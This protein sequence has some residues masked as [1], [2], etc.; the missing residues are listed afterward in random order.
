MKITVFLAAF[1]L[2]APGA[3]A[4]A[5]A[6]LVVNGDF[7]DGNTGFTSQYTYAAPTSGALMPETRYTIT[8]DP[9]SVHPYW[10]RVGGDN[11]IMVVNGATSAGK[12]VWQENIATIAGQAYQFTASAADVCCN[13]AHPGRYAASELEFEVSADNFAHFTTLATIDTAPPKDAGQF[14]TATAT[15][16]ATG[17]MELR[18]VDAL[19]GRVGND[20]ALDDIGV[21]ALPGTGGGSPASPGGADPSAVPE[22][23]SWALMI[24]GFAGLGAAARSRRRRML[25]LA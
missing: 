17:A 7:S 8:T 19:T 1:A 3:A 12:T 10:V 9:R 2:A 22:P 24:V 5:A 13:S 18:V 21:F 11:S 23:R 15:F 4:N 20:F 25:G 16:T 14:Q 6:N